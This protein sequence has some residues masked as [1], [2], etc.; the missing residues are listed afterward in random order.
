MFLKGP[1]GEYDN[2]D[3]DC[4]GANNSGG[5]CANDPSGQG[6]T[7]FVDIVS[8]F[9]IQDLDANIHSY[10]VFGNEGDNPS[11]APQ[12]HGIQPLSVMAVVCNDQVV[13]ISS[14]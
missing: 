14:E 3:V 8:K 2:M 6:Q 4:D 10:V 1:D 13:R 7:S 11:F 12:D 9:G 5:D